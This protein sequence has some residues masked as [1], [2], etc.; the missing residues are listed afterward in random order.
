MSI[1]RVLTRLQN[2]ILPTLTASAAVSR[3]T[4]V[5]DDAGGQT[6]TWATVATYPCSFAQTQIS[7]VEREN[8]ITVKSLTYW[9]FVFPADADV[10]PEDRI[11]V[12]SRTFEVVGAGQGSV[13]IVTRAICL[14]IQ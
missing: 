5:N 8:T 3:K 14:E 4:L 2:V 1:P 13:N 9:G 6:T 10:R 12:G 11:I 7:P